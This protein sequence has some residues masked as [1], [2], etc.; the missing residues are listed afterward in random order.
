MISE[1][2]GQ[3]CLHASILNLEIS[4]LLF[5]CAILWLSVRLDLYDDWPFFSLGFTSGRR[6]YGRLP[7]YPFTTSQ[8]V[9]IRT[10]LMHQCCGVRA[11]SFPRLQE[12]LLHPPSWGSGHI[13]ALLSAHRYLNSSNSSS[14]DRLGKPGNV[15]SNVGQSHWDFSA[16]EP[17]FPDVPKSPFFYRWLTKMLKYLFYSPTVDS[18]FNTDF[19]IFGW[20]TEQS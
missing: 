8:T 20:H 15:R 18:C 4:S 3:C 2:G 13:S 6:K 9:I 14:K 1:K 10:T 17:A 7:K 11:S 16:G 5:W 12:P 19:A